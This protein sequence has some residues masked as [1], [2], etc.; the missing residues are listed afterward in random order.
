MIPNDGRS[1]LL[2]F[3]AKVIDFHN[4][5]T[6]SRLGISYA[7]LQ[8]FLAH[9]L[10]GVGRGMLNE[11][12]PQY[13]PTWMEW[14]PELAMWRQGNAYPVLSKWLSLFAEYGLFGITML[15]LL[16]RF[17]YRVLKR[18]SNTGKYIEDREVFLTYKYYLINL[19]LALFFTVA[20]SKTIYLLVFAFFFSFAM[21]RYL[22]LN[23][24]TKVEVLK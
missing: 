21:Y 19:S 14:N 3:A 2:F 12:I 15:L 9:P 6:N 4:V 13:I 18:V 23:R 17:I 10:L 1:S 8:T 5:S 16:L 11:Y 24:T 22:L 20:W 7:L